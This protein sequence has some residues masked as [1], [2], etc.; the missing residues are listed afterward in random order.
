MSIVN[1]AGFRFVWTNNSNIVEVFHPQVSFP[2][3]PIEALLF[4]STPNEATI[5]KLANETREYARL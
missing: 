4:D 2:E 1:G 5:K 3:Y